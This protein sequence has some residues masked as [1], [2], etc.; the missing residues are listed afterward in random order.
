MLQN[1]SIAKTDWQHI[2]ISTN[3]VASFEKQI[4]NEHR[5]KKRKSIINL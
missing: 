4:I 3:C 5:H 2:S 1:R